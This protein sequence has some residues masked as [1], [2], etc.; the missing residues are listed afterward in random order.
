MESMSNPAVQQTQGNEDAHLI[1]VPEF[2]MSLKPTYFLSRGISRLHKNLHR[3]YSAGGVA[4]FLAG[5]IYE[6]A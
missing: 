3:R 6:H 1:F 4:K 2:L 5:I